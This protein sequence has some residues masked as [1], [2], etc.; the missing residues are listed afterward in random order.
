MYTT[1]CA[2]FEFILIC[3]LVLSEERGQWDG[4]VIDLCDS[5]PY[6]TNQ[7]DSFN[8]YLSRSLLCD[9]GNSEARGSWSE[10]QQYMRE[11]TDYSDERLGYT[12]CLTG[13]NTTAGCEGAGQ[14]KKSTGRRNGC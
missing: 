11:R 6:A 2:F 4:S 1:D 7:R 14:R 13:R 10:Q 8:S 3:E 5:H 9:G 12:K